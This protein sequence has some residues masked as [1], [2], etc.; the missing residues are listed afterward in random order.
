MIL[1]TF[2][3]EAPHMTGDDVAAWQRTLNAQMKAWR[4]NYGVEPHGDYDIATRDLSATVVFGLGIARS[5]MA[6]GVTPELRVK[7]RNR[8]LDAVERF[9]FARRAGWRRRLRERHAGGGAVAAPLIKIL[10]SSWGWHPGV[11]DGVDLICPPNATIFALCDARVIDVRTSGWW[12]KAP[13][14][15]VSK[16][17]GII[18][19]ECLADVGPFRRGMHFGYG[20]AEHPVVREGQIVKAGDPLGK[21]GFAVAWHVHFM[22]NGGGTT[23]GVGDRD[24]MPFVRYAVRH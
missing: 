15:D 22:A 2:K 23:K 20:H 8:T 21:A 9:R 16:G 5:S 19:L 10:Q 13:S 6:L 1:R 3:V 7:V 4:V 17:D 11:H 14:G 12:G 24:P 18:Q